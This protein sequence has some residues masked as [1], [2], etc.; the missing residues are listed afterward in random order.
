MVSCPLEV[1]VNSVIDPDLSQGVVLPSD[2]WVQVVER[3]FEQ[4]KDVET[5]IH[6]SSESLPSAQCLCGTMLFL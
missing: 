2:F 4:R 6:P 5:P 1:L 3:R